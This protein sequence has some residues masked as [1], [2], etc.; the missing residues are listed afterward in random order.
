MARINRFTSGFRCRWAVPGDRQRQGIALG[1]IK[2]FVWAGSWVVDCRTCALIKIFALLALYS[3]SL[4]FSHFA[5][6]LCTSHNLLK[7][8]ELLGLCSN[9]LHFSRFLQNLSTCYTFLILGL[10]WKS[11]RI[12]RRRNC[13][14]KGIDRPFGRGVESRLI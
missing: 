2:E 12:P 5:Q 3:K 14:F 6:N 9:S 8:F 7:I 13:F 10:C 11:L 1:A 4:H